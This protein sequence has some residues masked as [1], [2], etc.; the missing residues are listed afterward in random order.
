[1]MS[2]KIIK[3]KKEVMS[4]TNIQFLINNALPSISHPLR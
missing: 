4:D 2:L 3:V 1:M